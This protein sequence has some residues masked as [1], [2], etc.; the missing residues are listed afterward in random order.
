MG[1]SRT[2]KIL[3]NTLGNLVLHKI[4]ALHTN[5]P[6][7]AHHLNSEIEAYR[8][9]ALEIVREF[10]WSNSD[11][12]EIRFET[13]ANFRLDIHKKYPDVKFTMEEAERLVE[14]TIEEILNETI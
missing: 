1:K 9:N 11:I 13:L 3:G 4:L 12:E 6:E 5:K 14:E 8:D 2:I 7:S 10:N